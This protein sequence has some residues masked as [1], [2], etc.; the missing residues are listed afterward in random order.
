[1]PDFFHAEQ[2]RKNRDIG[3]RGHSRRKQAGGCFRD[4]QQAMILAVARD[5]HQTDRKSGATPLEPAAMNGAAFR[6]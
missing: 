2:V 4:A 3:S 5:Q 6:R 1:M